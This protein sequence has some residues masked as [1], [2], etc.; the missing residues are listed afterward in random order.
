MHH[1]MRHKAPHDMK[2]FDM[3]KRPSSSFKQPT[4]NPLRTFR[5]AAILLLMMM[6]GA[7]STWGQTNYVFYNATYG[8]LY[9]DNGALKSS[10]SLQFDK[11]SVWVASD[12]LGGTSITIQSF[13]SNLYL[14]YNGALSGTSSESW[15]SDGSIYY[16]YNRTNYY[17]KATNATTFTTTTGNNG[18]RY[19][20]YAVT[21]NDIVQGLSEFEITG[22]ESS[23]NATGSSTYGHTNSTYCDQ[24]YTH[25]NFNGNCG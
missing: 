1:E 5:L 22:G 13:T 16:R 20:P 23:F 21:I 10:A 19:T 7:Q 9:N 24:A 17:L 4:I 8:Y 15:R 14:G 25:Y 18:N 3:L 12:V 11:S 6:T 2:Q